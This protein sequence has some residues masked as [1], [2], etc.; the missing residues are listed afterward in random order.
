[1]TS[2]FCSIVLAAGNKDYGFLE[3]FGVKKNLFILSNGNRLLQESFERY[4]GNVNTRVVIGENDDLDE[5]KSY[6]DFQFLYKLPGKSPKGALASLLLA[7]DQYE[8]NTSVVVA[9]SDGLIP[10][11]QFSKFINSMFDQDVDCGVLIFPSSQ[12]TLSYVRRNTR[13][14]VIEIAEKKVISKYATAGIYYFRNSEL[15]LKCGEWAITNN[16]S[17]NGE[18]Y[19]SP[20]LNYF[21]T[22]GLKMKTYAIDESEYLRFGTSHEAKLNLG[23]FEK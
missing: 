20:A 15:I 21:V 7:L 2:T 5:L 9:P 19:I 14:E 1:M 11:N 16:I 13:E 17:F 4:K 3:T 18:F 23:R 8:V 22:N 6:I 10:H 12:E